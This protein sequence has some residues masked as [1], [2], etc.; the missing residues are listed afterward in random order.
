MTP[1]PFE[2]LSDEEVWSQ[3]KKS[4]DIALRN[5]LIERYAPLVKINAISKQEF[6]DA[7]AAKLQAAADV[8]AAKA[9]VAAKSDVPNA[10][11]PQ[12]IL[13][14]MVVSLLSEL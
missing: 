8:A 2:E 1:K 11:A 14:I 10:P 9:A 13:R 4:G 12:R 7:N 3:Y 5:G 6:D